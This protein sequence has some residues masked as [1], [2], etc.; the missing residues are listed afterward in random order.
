MVHDLTALDP[1]CRFQVTRSIR[2]DDVKPWVTAEPEVTETVLTDDDEY[3]DFNSNSILTV[4]DA[5][6]VLDVAPPRVLRI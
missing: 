1:R 6:R 3:L 4:A 2:D 5:A